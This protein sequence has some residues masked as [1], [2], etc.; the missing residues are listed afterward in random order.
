LWKNA[1]D[2]GTADD[3]TT[4]RQA[5]GLTTRCMRLLLWDTL[6]AEAGERLNFFRSVS[7]PNL[8]AVLDWAI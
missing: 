6:I 4:I 7:D 1:A 3:A 8:H 2:A 5:K